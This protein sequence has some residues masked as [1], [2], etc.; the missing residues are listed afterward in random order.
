[1]VDTTY[2]DDRYH[3]YIKTIHIIVVLGNNSD[4]NESFNNYKTIYLLISVII[5]KNKTT[6]N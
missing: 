6:I 1:M 4:I 3:N 5:K 2:T